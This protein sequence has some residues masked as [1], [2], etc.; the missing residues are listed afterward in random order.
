MLPNAAVI[1]VLLALFS[2]G[3][4]GN[5]EANVDI[6]HHLAARKERF[7]RFVNQPAVFRRDLGSGSGAGSGSGYDRSSD[8]DS[9]SDS[10]ACLPES[11]EYDRRLALLQCDSEEYIRAVMSDIETSNCSLY[12]YNRTAFSFGCG[13]NHNGD[14]CAGIDDSVYNDFYR[15]CLRRW[16]C[17]GDCDCSSECKKELRQ[18]SDSE[19]CCIHSNDDA[20][21]PSVWKNCNIQQPEVCADTPKIADIFAKRNVDPCT[22]ECAQRHFAYQFCKHL[23]K[24]FEQLNRECGFEDVLFFCAYDKGRFCH[25][26]NYIF[27][28]YPFFQ[29][30]Y[31]ECYSEGSSIRDG[32]CSAVCK[33][34]VEELIDRIG[35]CVNGNYNS[36]ELLSACGIEAPDA[37]TSFDSTVV[38]DDFLEC[39]GLTFNDNGAA[40]Q[41]GVYNIGVIAIGLI[42]IYIL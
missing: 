42:A 8:S 32:V 22:E 41:S 26:S 18:L 21:T 15:P 24:R 19:G 36:E 16:D 34:L 39:A 23:G 29:A 33:N 7:L 25:D 17:R 9:D 1:C 2:I 12:F 28:S 38:P 14:V 30:L 4:Q 6:P 27:K 11:R 31:D 35:C 40:L 13:T 10:E 5:K 37:C 3:S 20:S